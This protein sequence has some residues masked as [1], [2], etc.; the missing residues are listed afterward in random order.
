MASKSGD[1]AIKLTLWWKTQCEDSMTK[2]MTPSEQRSAPEPPVA[3]CPGV[4]KD[5]QAE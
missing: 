5:R 4:E 2:E 3:A 1:E